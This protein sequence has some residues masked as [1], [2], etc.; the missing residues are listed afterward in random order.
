MT[1]KDRQYRFNPEPGKDYIP[2]TDGASGDAALP[3]TWINVEGPALGSMRILHES[4]ADPDEVLTRT[5]LIAKGPD[6]ER[7]LLRIED[8]LI[9]LLLIFNQH[10]TEITS[11]AASLMGHPLG[12]ALDAARVALG[13]P[14]LFENTAQVPEPDADR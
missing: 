7:A 4:C 9:D 14:S 8:K 3:I 12:E 11:H 2:A 6:M 13:K 5:E 10:S 1:K